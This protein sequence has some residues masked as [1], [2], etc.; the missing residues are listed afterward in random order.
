[1]ELCFMADVK[2]FKA[3]RHTEKS[4]AIIK[5]L[6]KKNLEVFD[7]PTNAD[8]SIVISGY[9]ENPAILKGRKVLVVD[10]TEWFKGLPAPNGFKLAQPVLEEYYDDFLNLSGMKPGEK[11]I[12]IKKYI[13]E[14]NQ[15]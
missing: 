15:S 1:M 14:V 4:E 3:D 13:D 6:R 8:I 9:Y 12:E 5:E 11:A 2:I 7:T 10:V